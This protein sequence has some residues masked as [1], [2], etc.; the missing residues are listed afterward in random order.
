MGLA[1]DLLPKREDPSRFRKLLLRAFVFPSIILIAAFALMARTIQ[2]LEARARLVD[3]TDQVIADANLLTR[4]IIDEETGLRGYI[5]YRDKQFL[6]PFQKAQATIDQHF[7]QL[8]QLVADNPEQLKKL[9]SIQS[10]FTRWRL[11]AESSLAGDA[12]N[13]RALDRKKMMDDLRAQLDDFI[14]VEQ[15]LRETREDSFGTSSRNLNAVAVVVLGL[16]TVL[17]GL[18][19]LLVL[20][21]L[22]KAYE[23]QLNQVKKE[24]QHAVEQEAWLRTTLKSIGDA[25]IACDT[26]GRVMFMN[27][28]AERLTGWLTVDAVKR[29]LNEVFRIVNATSR[30][31][32]ESPVEKVRRFGV[33]VG[34][35]NHT[36]LIRRDGLESHIDDSAAPIVDNAGEMVGVVL[37]FRDVTDRRKAE[38]A[39]LKAEKLASAG[40]LSAAIA[41]E[42]NNP[43]EALT[44]LLFLAEGQLDGSPARHLIQQAEIEVDRIAHITR[45]SLGFFRDGTTL[46]LFSAADHLNQIVAFYSARATVKGITLKTTLRSDVEILGSPGEFRQVFSNLLSNAMDACTAGDSIHVALSK[47]VDRQTGRIG[48]RVTVADSGYGIEFTKRSAVFEPF[49]TT[50]GSTGTGLGLWV[51]RQL[52]EKHGG[53]IRMRSRTGSERRGTTFQ[54]FLPAVNAELA[55]ASESTAEGLNP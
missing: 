21:Q 15:G 40:R 4:L 50:K 36:V 32:V 30:T 49:Y 44:N 7:A 53:H 25:V 52:V 13:E 26:D 11:D 51:T 5:A 41:H 45:Q 16:V 6:E 14:V 29:P 31:I 35:A 1:D 47:T 27:V 28:V 48:A 22:S 18:Y 43:L 3:H 37:T 38:D 33:T 34:L 12:S 19:S 24:R 39:L 42:V 54:V 23:D 17:I 10:S 2:H 8:S 55:Q 9:A 20:R 46:K